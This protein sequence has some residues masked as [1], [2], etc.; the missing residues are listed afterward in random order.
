MSSTSNSD[1]EDLGSEAT[2]MSAVSGAGAAAA[3]TTVDFSTKLQSV[4]GGIS[5]FAT[6][7]KTAV[8]KPS[9]DEYLMTLDASVGIS[10]FP[11]LQKV[12]DEEVKFVVILDR[13]GSMGGKPWNQ[14]RTVYTNILH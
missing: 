14:V 1:W 3:T 10:N 2:T 4:N 6:D 12:K 11:W 13:S 9:A 5:L 8:G 7:P